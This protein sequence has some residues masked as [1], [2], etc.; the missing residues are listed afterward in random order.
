MASVDT[1]YQDVKSKVDELPP[2][3]LGKV[4]EQV[5]EVG[6]V[7]VMGSKEAITAA[8]SGRDGWMDVVEV[9]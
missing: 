2:D 7:V 1:K 5:S 4:L 9:L 3:D 6:Q 8:N